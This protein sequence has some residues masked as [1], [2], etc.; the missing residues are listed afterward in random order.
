MKGY[1]YVLGNESL[2][3]V[4]KV[5]GT[6]KSPEIRAK[7]LS[8]TSVPTPYEVL[9][10]AE[11]DDWRKSESFIHESLSKHRVADNREFFACSLQDIEHE[12][13]RL[14][15][16]VRPLQY[17]IYSS[18]GGSG[19]TTVALGLA[20]YYKEKGFS[21]CVSEPSDDRHD[22]KTLSRKYGYD[23]SEPQVKIC[24]APSFRNNQTIELLNWA[25]EHEA[26]VI[27]PT[28]VGPTDFGVLYDDILDFKKTKIKPYVLFSGVQYFPNEAEKISQSIITSQSLGAIVLP[29]SI[30]HSARFNDEFNDESTLSTP[31]SLFNVIFEGI[32]LYFE[33]EDYEK[34]NE[35]NEKEILIQ[36]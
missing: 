24:V 1:V 28:R 2:P 7:E 36:A 6:T 31:Y 23:S 27:I 20:C 25:I 26:R 21:V 3:G 30:P 16:S 11:V 10:S 29:Y 35:A 8:N 14:H 33:Y 5:G 9:L 17:L 34:E 15:K 12:F 4:Y 18:K 22:T 32:S 19:S 13:D